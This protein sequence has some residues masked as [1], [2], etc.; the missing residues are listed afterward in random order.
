MVIERGKEVGRRIPVAKIL[1]PARFAA[2]GMREH[3]AKELKVAAID[4]A[5]RWTG[6]MGFAIH[7]RK[8]GDVA[9]AAD[10]PSEDLGAVRLTAIFDDANTARARLPDDLVGLGRLAGGMHQQDRRNIGAEPLAQLLDPDIVA[11]GFAVAEAR[12]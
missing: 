9:K 3:L 12:F 11:V 8:G 1:A 10:R 6:H 4:D 5:A 2:V 7:R